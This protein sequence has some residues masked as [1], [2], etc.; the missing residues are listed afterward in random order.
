MKRTI[1]EFSDIDSSGQ[2]GARIYKICK[3]AEYCHKRQRETRSSCVKK[4]QVSGPLWCQANQ[5]LDLR[6]DLRSSEGGEH[7]P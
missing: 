7:H 1:A 3:E 2:G 6:R 4:Y 5:W